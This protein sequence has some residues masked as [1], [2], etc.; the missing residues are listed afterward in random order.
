L[1]AAVECDVRMARQNVL[2]VRPGMELI[3]LSV[4]NGRGFDR[5]LQLLQS[6]LGRVRNCVP[7]SNDSDA[8]AAAA[9]S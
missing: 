6:L 7:K 3:E 5:W 2:A 9:G 4:K 1:A 8:V